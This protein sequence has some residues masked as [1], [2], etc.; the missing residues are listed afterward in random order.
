MSGKTTY[1]GYV[2]KNNQVVVRRTEIPGNDHNQYVHVL[3]CGD[4]GHEYGS[5]KIRGVNLDGATG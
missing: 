2:N 1:P 5:I 4:C 3:R